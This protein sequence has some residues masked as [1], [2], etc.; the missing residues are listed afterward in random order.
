MKQ[1]TIAI[2]FACVLL[3]FGL[4][5]VFSSTGWLP[6]AKKKQEAA[7]LTDSYERL[8]IKNARLL[9]KI[10]SIQNNNAPLEGLARKRFGLIGNN[11]TFYFVDK[12][13]LKQHTP[14]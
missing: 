6:L 4:Q 2:V 13:L 10:T 8:R 5:A 3:W 9:T 7:A 1:L 12:Q 14:R 11:E